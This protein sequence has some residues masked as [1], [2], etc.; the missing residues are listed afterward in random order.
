MNSIGTV[1]FFRKLNEKRMW[2]VFLLLIFCILLG[3]RVS[4]AD[5]SAT[6]VYRMY[7]SSIS[8]HFYTIDANEKNSATAGGFYTYEGVA[9]YAYK[10]QVS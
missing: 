7:S 10:T 5:L 6:P 8:D 2:L 9:F 1:I 4:A 3:G